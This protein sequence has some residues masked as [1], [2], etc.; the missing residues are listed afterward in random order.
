MLDQGI[1]VLCV[2]DEIEISHP[3][4]S[5]VQGWY[6][7]GRLIAQHL[8]NILEQ[9]G[10]ILCIGGNRTETQ[11]IDFGRQRLQGIFDVLSQYPAIELEIV[12][13]YW[14][15]DTALTH[16]AGHFEAQDE[17]LPNA[18]LGLS[19]SLALACKDAARSVGWLSK[20]TK[21]GGING[22]PTAL[23]GILKGTFE[24]TVDIRAEEFARQVVSLARKAA[25]GES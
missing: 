23:S 11:N 9:Q 18:I 7:A 21:I 14:D 4:F 24:A 6:D 1:P 15:Y 22:E 13:S 8:A 16:L 20:A 3:L 10:R 5:S 12:Q 17:I 25:A 2:E 19:D